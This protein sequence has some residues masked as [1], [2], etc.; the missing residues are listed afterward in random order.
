M[1]FHAHKR[2]KTELAIHISQKQVGNQAKEL[3][4]KANTS[5]IF[6]MEPGSGKT[7]ACCAYI[8]ARDQDPQI[9]PEDLVLYIAV[10]AKL[11]REQAS[12]MKCIIRVPFKK[13]HIP[14]LKKELEKRKK[15]DPSIRIIMT[16]SMFKGYFSERR[17]FNDELLV[18][19]GSP[20]IH[21]ALDEAHRYYIGNKRMPTHLNNLAKYACKGLRVTGLTATPQLEDERNAARARTLFGSD[22][23]PIDYTDEQKKAFNKDLK[24]HAS[25][26]PSWK[27]KQMPQPKPDD[28]EREFNALSIIT[29]GNARQL[30]EKVDDAPPHVSFNAWVARNNLT[31]KVTTDQIH[32]NEDTGG[33]LFKLV[34]DPIDWNRFDGQ[35]LQEEKVE[36]AQAV[37]VVNRSPAGSEVHFRSL[38]DLRGTEG[39][40]NFHLHD[41][42]TFDL[43]ASKQGLEDLFKSV[44]GTMDLTIAFVDKGQVEGTNDYS[45]NVSTIVAVGEWTVAEL[46]QLK[47]RLSRPCTLEEKDLVPTN[48]KLHHISSKWES[49]VKS[50][51]TT[52]H[53][54]RNTKITAALKSRIEQLDEKYKDK[55]YKM[56]DGFK[57]FGSDL[58]TM[59]LDSMDPESTFL[60][61]EYDEEVGKWCKIKDAVGMQTMMDDDTD[62]DDS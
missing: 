46:E 15:G 25:T 52:R 23:T 22:P 50:I 36:R 10:N 9:E 37:L 58:V 62:A 5:I 44:T 42:R 18:P 38:E 39:V 29:V 51:G 59:Y 19:L 30:A 60:E 35:T 2:S 11:G 57:L 47:G 48:Y 26:P 43:E 14:S 41:L 21:I 40:R 61:K 7:R 20:R 13:A 27:E 45:K 8:D 54:A 34:K 33:L 24:K 6:A 55:A 1:S 28:F 53:S 4:K 12:E 49:E 17:N 3:S 56:A 16:Q 31:A 32:G